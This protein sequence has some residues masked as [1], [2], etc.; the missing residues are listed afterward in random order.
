MIIQGTLLTLIAKQKV[1][2]L[3]MIHCREIMTIHYNENKKRIKNFEVAP[4]LFFPPQ[5]NQPI[6]L[7]SC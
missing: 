6:T 7:C 3:Y 1:I 2:N 5:Q 4:P